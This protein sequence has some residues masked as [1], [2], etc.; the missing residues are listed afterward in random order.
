MNKECKN[1]WVNYEITQD[2]LNFYDK[3]SPEFNWKKYQIP[4]PTFCPNCRQQRRLAWRNE[5]KLY[6]RKCD[7]SWK[8][9]IS[10]YSPDKTST[11]YLRS[12]WWSDKWDWADYWIIFDFNK[13][14]FYQFQ[15]LLSQVPRPS[16]INKNSQNCDY[17]NNS[18]SDKDCYL[19]FIS[20]YC[21]NCYYS[22]ASFRNKNCIDVLWTFL[23]ESCYGCIKIENCYNCKF[24][25]NSRNC[26]DSDYL[27]NCIW[28]KN[29]CFCV[30]LRHKQYCFLN[31]QYSKKDYEIINNNLNNEDFLVKT[32]ND[33]DTLKQ[34]TPLKNIYIEKS[35]DCTWDY[36]ENSKNCKSCFDVSISR[37]CKYCFD[38]LWL[39]DCIDTYMCA[40]C[41]EKTK[42]ELTYEWENI[43]NGY[44][45]IFSSTA[46]DC[47][48]SA[49]LDNC[50]HC[51]D[52]FW[53]T[54]LRH[55][56]Y[57]ILN[58]QYTKEEYEKLVPRIIEHM[59]TPHPSTDSIWSYRSEWWEFFPKN[60]SLFTY[61]ET[62]AQ[63]Y[64]PLSK[65][66][67]LNKWL[68]WKD[69][70]NSISNVTK[71]IPAERL[72]DNIKDIPDDILNWAIKCEVSGRPFKII[73][74]ELEFY[75]KHNIPV[76]HLHPDERHK[77]R[78]KLRNPRKL[79]DRQCMKCDKGIQ[80]TYSPDRSE[81]VYCEECYLK[82]VY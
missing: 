1:C 50:F 82:E 9:I 65:E 12:E 13:W 25:I 53:C 10:I 74:Q 2:D 6:K 7:L 75:R 31:K 43:I 54:W 3:V 63:V 72:P 5:T 20:W 37:D 35:E 40:S 77:A 33:F 39:N 55:K 58:K 78:M 46:W 48:N 61:N 45:I 67:I 26:S 21:E 17:C 32:K 64:Y 28:I 80:T 57:C 36:I 14:F 73:P 44:N 29:S 4:A 11:V 52:C 71:I 19:I 59:N 34:N 68:K 49:Y 70:D 79:Y 69:E 23:S 27:S 81:I 62:I 18:L 76:P 56:Q 15:K 8:N 38:W 41:D 66:G 22:Y 42:L 30:W 16:I 47:S 60:I 51:K 24:C